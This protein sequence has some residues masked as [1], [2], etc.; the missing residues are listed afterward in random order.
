MN[1]SEQKFCLFI[2]VKFM[3]V[4]GSCTTLIAPV[5]PEAMLGWAQQVREPCI[6]VSAPALNMLACRGVALGFRLKQIQWPETHME[7][8]QKGRSHSSSP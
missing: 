5:K 7:G 3:Q 8:A 1:F 4:H 6:G 2:R